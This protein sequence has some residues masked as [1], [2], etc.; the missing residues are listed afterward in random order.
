MPCGVV[1]VLKTCPLW[2]TLYQSGVVKVRKSRK[3]EG[4]GAQQE[5]KE[6]CQERGFQGVEATSIIRNKGVR[7]LFQQ[8]VFFHVMFMALLNRSGF[9]GFVF[10]DESCMKIC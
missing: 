4:G 2:Q 3:N 8:K 7:Q 9:F 10:I 5:K 6:G 1:W